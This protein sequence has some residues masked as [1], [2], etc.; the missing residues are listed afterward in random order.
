MKRNKNDRALFRVH[1]GA[2]VVAIDGNIDVRDILWCV[3]SVDPINVNRI[4]VQ[5]GLNNK[6]NI[7]FSYYERKTF[8]KN[9]PNANN[10]LFDLGMASGMERPQYIIIGFE[11]NNVNEQSHDAIT[12][13]IM[14]VTECYCKIGIEF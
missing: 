1:A 9:V 14:N 4:N 10:F 8:Y 5:K 3:P 12:F 13:D 6:N 7:D 11:Y 2:D